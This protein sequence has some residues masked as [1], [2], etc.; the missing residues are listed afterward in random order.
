MSPSPQP[1]T[2]ANLMQKVKIDFSFFTSKLYVHLRD[3]IRFGRSQ[4]W[5]WGE[6]EWY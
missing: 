2:P 5:Y 4:Y 6:L 3:N 1:S